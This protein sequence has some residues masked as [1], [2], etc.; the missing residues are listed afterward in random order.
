MADKADKPTKQGVSAPAEIPMDALP[1]PAPTPRPERGGSYRVQDGVLV[2]I[3]PP[4]APSPTAEEQ[5]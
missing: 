3:D 1:A 4:T 5:R 2:E